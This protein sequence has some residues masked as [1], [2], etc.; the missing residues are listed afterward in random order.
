MKATFDKIT[1]VVNKTCGGFSV[2]CVV[3]CVLMT[4]VL[5]A[6]VVL[7]KVTHGAVT[8]KG[9]YEIAQM[10]LSMFIF[11]SWGY[12][13]SV[14]G[15]IH[16]VMFIQ[17]MKRIPRLICFGITS[18]LSTITV[19]IGAYAV[20]HKVFDMYKTGEATS[21]LLIPHWP[22]YAFECIAFVLLTLTLLLDTCKAFAAMGN[23][24]LQAEVESTWE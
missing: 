21:N 20:Y 19:G 22:F 1:T 12:V 10:L 24:E 16:V 23:D 7:R 3:S 13:Q 2:L 4:L 17:K 14:H 5:F 9:A 8:V 11:A 18:L 15:H 6:D